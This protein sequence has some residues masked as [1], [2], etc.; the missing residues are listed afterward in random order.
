MVRSALPFGLTVQYNLGSGLTKRYTFNLFPST[1]VIFEAA[2]GR[3]ALPSKRRMNY[4][5]NCMSGIGANLTHSDGALRGGFSLF[6]DAN[7]VNLDPD[8]A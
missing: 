8:L 4:L 2:A 6:G 3:I 7:E 1:E 5:F